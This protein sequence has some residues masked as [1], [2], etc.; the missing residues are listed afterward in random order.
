MNIVSYAFIAGGVTEYPLSNRS[1]YWKFVLGL[2]QE[3][4]GGY[5]D[6]DASFISRF[7][8][9]E[10]Q[11]KVGKELVLERISDKRQV[12][13]L[14]YEKF[15]IMWS[16]GDS[17]V[18]WSMSNINRPFVYQQL[19]IIERA[20]YFIMLFCSE[21]LDNFTPINIIFFMKHCNL[22]LNLVII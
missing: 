11:D 15:K 3:T 5:S 19:T 18:T 10:E 6:E 2:N 13:N 14:F 20:T 7:P 17:S 9:G 8:L 16:H 1:P 12:V 22:P 21:R 4:N